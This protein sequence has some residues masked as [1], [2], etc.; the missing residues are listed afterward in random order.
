MSAGAVSAGPIEPCS[1]G[2]SAAAKRLAFIAKMSAARCV[3]AD[4]AR[5]RC[6]EG[7]PVCKSNNVRRSRT[8]IRDRKVS[9]SQ[10]T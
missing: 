5:Q 4:A 7:Q 6:G 8:C 9:G 10:A 1:E 3:P 2:R